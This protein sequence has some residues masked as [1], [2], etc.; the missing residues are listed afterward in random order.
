MYDHCCRRPRMLAISLKTVGHVTAQVE[1]CLPSCCLGRDLNVD[2][3]HSIHAIYRG[4]LRFL[5]RFSAH[6]RHLMST[7]EKRLGNISICR[8]IHP[9]SRQTSGLCQLASMAVRFI[10]AR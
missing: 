3:M 7:A 4:I 8:A 6:Q 2:R 1:A 5:V 9:L 10:I